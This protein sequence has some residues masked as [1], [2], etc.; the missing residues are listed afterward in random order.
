MTAGATLAYFNEDPTRPRRPGAVTAVAIIGIVLA[1]LSVMGNA[2]GGAPALV[3][4]DAGPRAFD[5]PILLGR[6]LGVAFTLLMLVGC[7]GL[8][9]LRPVARWLVVIAAYAWL[10]V[11]ALEA[12]TYVHAMLSPRAPS[13]VPPTRAFAPLAIYAIFA[14]LK[15]VAF[16]LVALLV[17]RRRAAG[18]LFARSA[19]AAPADPPPLARPVAAVLLA[20]A[21]MWVIQ[22][23]AEAAMLLTYGNGAG[24]SYPRTRL[25][26][27][28]GVPGAVIANA[29][30]SILLHGVLLVGCVLVLARQRAGTW[31]AAAGCI[32]KASLSITA[33]FAAGETYRMMIRN[34]GAATGPM[35]YQWVAMFANQM[36]SLVWPALAL[37]VFTYRPPAA[38]AW[39]AP[40]STPPPPPRSRRP[41]PIPP[42]M[43]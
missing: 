6:M 23:L 9:G 3:P 32:A 13:F 8:L 29:A 2:L 27:S 18:E 21:V 34:S 36:S 11:F 7:V 39:V 5:P 1:A 19:P 35:I 41:P 4:P 20:F 40:R 15:G 16:P 38:A 33:W 24:V 17:L 31:L 28:G 42:A 22:A 26:A 12:T 43:S 10:V 14:I 30:V 37:M 25:S